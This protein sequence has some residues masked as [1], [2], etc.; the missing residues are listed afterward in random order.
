M[1][2]C[3]ACSSLAQL[4]RSYLNHPAMD[5]SGQQ[6]PAPSSIVTGLE[7]LSRKGSAACSVCAH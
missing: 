6:T 1:G 7:G 2:F 5:L 3:G 4:D